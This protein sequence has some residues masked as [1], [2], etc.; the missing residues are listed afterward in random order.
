MT[1]RTKTPDR[2]L[3]ASRRL[4]NQKGYA[5]TSLSEIAAAV[6]ISQGNLTY[7]FPTKSDLAQRIVQEARDQVRVR[8]QNL[9]PGPIADDYVDHLLF[10][11]KLTWS[12]RFLLR[13]RMHF[14]DKVG[15]AETLMTADFE[16]LLSLLKRIE[17][18]SMFLP[19]AVE[20]LDRLTR[21]IWVMSRYWIDYLRDVEGL[22]D[23]R[24]ADQER[25]MEHHFA[26]LLPCLKAPA[27]REFR[28]ALARAKSV[29]D[30]LENHQI[31]I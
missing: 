21:S 25:G 2:I 28:D 17:A 18:E 15:R 6:G 4:F 9:Q 30:A 8:H 7:H 20:D 19:G 11:M 22:D 5:A 12:N 10:A 3:E 16:E 24:W 29:E 26:I 31:R 14:Q 1:A 27:K 23:I 13:D